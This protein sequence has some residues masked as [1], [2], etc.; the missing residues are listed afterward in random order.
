[1]QT[2]IPFI[3]GWLLAS[4]HHLWILIGGIVALLAYGVFV[5]RD[6]MVTLLMSLYVALALF[7]SAPLMTQ[8][9]QSLRLQ[10]RS[11]IPLTWFFCLFFVVFFLLYRSDIFAGLSHDLGTW[12]QAIFLVLSQIG[13]LVSIVLSLLPNTVTAPIPREIS[14]LFISD[15]ARTVWL[16]APLVFLG[17][18]S[19]RGSTM[20]LS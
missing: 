13:L 9:S 3:R 6:R 18:F 1:M 7:T 4:S 8:I 11:T 15:V 5:G 17:C 10:D 12:W 19:R 16:V 14:Q 2:I 20:D